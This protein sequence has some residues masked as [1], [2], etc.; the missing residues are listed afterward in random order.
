LVLSSAYKK[1]MEQMMERMLAKMDSFQA[2]MDANHE[3]MMTKLYAYHER[4][5]ASVNA[6]RKETMACQEATEVYSDKMEAD[7]EE[8]KS[9][10]E[11]EKD[12]KEDATV[13]TGRAPNKQHRGWHLATGHRS[14]L[15]ERTRGNC[16]SQKK[17]AAASRKMNHQAGVAQ[18]KVKVHVIRK[19]QT[20][21]KER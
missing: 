15:E 2:K 5:K 7:A 6:W 14:Q 8:M 13:E 10:A 3:E 20:R 18:C 11:Q 21:D 17:L 4:M 12:P 19:N 9:V 16:G 1:K